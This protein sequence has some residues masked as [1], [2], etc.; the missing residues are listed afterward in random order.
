MEEIENELQHLKSMV[1][2]NERALENNR[3]Q[4]VN[5]T[6]DALLLSQSKPPQ[7]LNNA[8]FNL[9]KPQS[10][11]NVSPALKSKSYLDPQLAPS[12]PFSNVPSPTQSRRGATNSRSI[13]AVHLDEAQIDFLFQEF[14]E[15]YH[16]FLPFLD[17]SMSPDE[18]SDASPLLF[19][20]IISIASRR[21]RAD[22]LLLPSLSKYV[23]QLAWTTVS[24]PPI[25]RFEVQALLLICFWQFPSLTTL[26]AD[27]S[28]HFVTIAINSA[29]Q[30]G[31][32]RPDFGLEFGT[33]KNRVNRR[34]LTEPEKFEATK[35]WAACNIVAQQYVQML[36]GDQR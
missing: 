22:P 28:L 35:T 23:T 36:V 1:R 11:Q 25:L 29:M 2:P 10:Y 13:E 7:P 14:F 26:K 31:L 19:W 9:L 12:P 30:S 24:D 27:P 16:P 34:N 21:Y 18:C 6:K 4:V 8:Q 3:P 5:M 32:H 33:T 17:P 20:S 15:R